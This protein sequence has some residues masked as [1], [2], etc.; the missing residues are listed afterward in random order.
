MIFSSLKN[1]IR[2][3]NPTK[4]MIQKMT[5]MFYNIKVTDYLNEDMIK[6]IKASNNPKPTMQV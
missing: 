4:H 5:I 1:L 2:K 6:S 3:V